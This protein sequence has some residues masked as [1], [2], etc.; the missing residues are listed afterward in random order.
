MLPN[1][2]PDMNET[3]QPFIPLKNGWGIQPIERFPGGEDMHDNFHVDQF[4]DISGGHTTIR[5]P[6]NQDVHLLW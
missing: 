4:G 1:G 6:G 3:F 2:M 5:L